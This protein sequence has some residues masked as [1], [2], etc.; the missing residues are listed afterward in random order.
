MPPSPPLVDDGPLQ[1]ALDFTVDVRAPRGRGA[2][3]LWSDGRHVVTCS[4]VA[5]D[6]EIE[7]TLPGREAPIASRL[8]R[9]RAESDLALLELAE[10][11]ARPPVEP[12]LEPLRPGEVL[13]A[14]GNPWGEH[15]ALTAGVAFAAPTP[16][17]WV[18]A[19]LRVAPGNSGGPL[20]DSRGRLVG[21]VSLWSGGAAV[22]VPVSEV[23]VLVGNACAASRF[24]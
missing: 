10:P 5:A 9:R 8:V 7:I 24:I 14:V 16:G 11:V 12:R 19:D 23:M 22:A 15:G 3:V 1:R 13:F 21:V 6:N 18:V 20:V 17:G 2:G 4:H